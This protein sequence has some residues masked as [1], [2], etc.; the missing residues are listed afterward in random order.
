MSNPEFG[1]VGGTKFDRQC[2]AGSYVA[3]ISGETEGYVKKICLTCSDGTDLGCVGV[4]GKT[5]Y[6]YEG[7]FS[8]VTGRAGS[9]IDNLLGEGGNGG[10]PFTKACPENTY[11]SG[12]S[13]SHGSYMDGLSF[14]CGYTKPAAGDTAKKGDTGKK[15]DGAK[16]DDGDF[17]GIPTIAWIFIL[18]LVCAVVGW[19]IYALVKSGPSELDK[20]NNRPP[21]NRQLT[22]EYT[23]AMPTPNYMNVPGVYPPQQG[24]LNEQRPYPPQ[25]PFKAP[26]PSF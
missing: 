5:P 24:S 14:N 23:T 26:G 10:T 6:S 12:I 21:L 19:G 1:G 20:F 9:W 3:K 11:L 22:P 7:P 16:K 18:I 2:P 25:R 13:G 15:D 4:P 17:L 8:V